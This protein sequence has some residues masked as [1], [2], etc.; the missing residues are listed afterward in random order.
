MNSQCLVGFWKA[1]PS[2]SDLWVCYLYLE[3]FSRKAVLLSANSYLETLTP[4]Q[5]F[6]TGPFGLIAIFSQF[7]IVISHKSLDVPF[8]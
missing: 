3:N 5:K 4:A 1:W 2:A 6:Y 7:K 8:S